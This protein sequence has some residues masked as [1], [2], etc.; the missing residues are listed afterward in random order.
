MNLK[1]HKILRWLMPGLLAL[2]LAIPSAAEPADIPASMLG[3]YELTFSAA[4]HQAP[5]ADG[6]TTTMVL[7]PGGVMC[8]ADYIVINPLL[9]ND[10]PY[11]AVWTVPEASVKLTLSDLTTG[12]NEVNVL[13]LSGAFQGQ[14]SGGQI[15]DSTECDLLGGPP[16]DMSDINELFELAETLYPDLF[17][18]DVAASAFRVLDGYIYREYTGTGTYI[19]ING[20]SVYLLGGQFGDTPT[21]VGTKA[22]TLLQLRA[23]AADS[24]SNDG[25]VDEPV[26]EPV[27]DAPEGNYTLTID[28]TVSGSVFGA[29]FNEPFT[30]VLEN[31]QAP[32][33]NDIEA[34]EQAVIDAMDEASDS[35][36]TSTIADIEVSEISV[37]DTRV[38][39]RV[40]FSATVTVQGIAVTSSYDLTYEY[41]KQ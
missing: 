24:D 6:A 25:T 13:T 15:S 30:A 4:N 39:F 27:V 38:F 3:T 11:E 40:V 17:S 33:T 35:V 20:S 34:V 41:L 26:E 2:S 23:E 37:S 1:R 9:E 10:N 29:S 12:F 8:I 19:G 36:D 18:T 7:A 21:S 14:F 28:G 31:M 5:V 16:P 22:N 32:D